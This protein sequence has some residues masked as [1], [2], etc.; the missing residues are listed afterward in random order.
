MA[1][2]H[3]RILGAARLAAILA[4]VSGVMSSPSYADPGSDPFTQPSVTAPFEAGQM[5]SFPF[6]DGRPLPLVPERF[7]QK[8]DWPF[9]DFFQRAVRQA[10]VRAD[11]EG[12]VIPA[13]SDPEAACFT[14]GHT[15]M[16]K[17]RDATLFILT[18][19][20]DGAWTQGTGTIV[21]G[22]GQGSA[23]RILTAAHAIE[24]V[25]PYEGEDPIHGIFA[26]DA[27]GRFLATLK[28][29]L[30]GDHEVVE[31]HQRVDRQE[32]M[33]PSIANDLAVLEVDTFAT[34]SIRDGWNDRGLEVAP[35]QSAHVLFLSQRSD[36]WAL[37]PGASG[38][39]VL[40]SEG[41]IIGVNV[42]SGWTGTKAKSAP[43]TGFL[44][45]LSE[46]EGDPDHFGRFFERIK[47][48]RIE[49][50]AKTIRYGA[51]MISLPVR[52][53]ELRQA[54]ALPEV[55]ADAAPSTQLG[56]VAA[57]PQQECAISEVRAHPVIAWPAQA[58]FDPD[59]LWHADPPALAVADASFEIR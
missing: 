21:K 4:C 27:D 43:D 20:E 29:V 32:G 30:R 52:Q 42:Y 28:P 54:L 25:N 18:T 11:A 38:S 58:Q 35:S 55:P 33:P 10:K 46:A 24:P 1:R 6:E 7:F 50:G 31:R 34:S 53:A 26:Y 5:V 23:D 8:N 3:G 9:V 19:Y 16:E 57:Y 51:S 17:A 59:R 13:P 12:G 40:D 44:D 56:I 15:L 22:S 48:Q 45:R 36:G 49:E 37:N 47:A 41:R 2:F 39:S 14:T